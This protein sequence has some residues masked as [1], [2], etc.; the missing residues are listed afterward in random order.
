M[1]KH[2]K[3]SGQF[4]PRTV[5]MLRSPAIRILSLTGRRI[6]DRIEIELASHGGKDN[7][8]LPVTFADLKK[9]GVHNRSDIARG[10]REVCALGFVELTRRG[11]AGN[12]EFR[13]PN[14]FRLTYLPAHGKAPTHDWR[15]FETTE[16]A[17]QA[18]RKN[19]KP[20][21]EN[22]TGP[23]TENV[24]VTGHGKR[25]ETRQ[26]PVTENGPL[27]RQDLSISGLSIREITE[28]RERV[29]ARAPAQ[30]QVRVVHQPYHSQGRPSWQRIRNCGRMIQN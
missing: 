21:T 22:V 24:T 11:R 10:I 2:R 23:V 26:S 15:R 3:I 18:A 9:F 27:S 12:G 6:L 1:S 30:S 13:S 5:E 19:R 7:G 16:E 4:V 8:K 17:E 25:T 14:L 28:K 20:V 29:A